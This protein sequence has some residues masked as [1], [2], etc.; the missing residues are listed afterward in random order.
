MSDYDKEYY[1]VRKRPSDRTLPFLVPDKN[2][3][4]K[5]FGFEPQPPGSPPLVFYNGW[6]DEYRQRR[7][8]TS[9]PDILF[10]GS[11]L[12]V[13][14]PIRNRLLALNVPN[15]DMQSAVYIDDRDQ[16]H[17]D[18]WYLTFLARFECWDREK[19]DYEQEIEPI[20]LGGFELYQ[21]YEYSLDEKLLDNTPLNQ[22]L[23]FQM[24]GTILA[25]V[26]CHESVRHLFD[27]GGKSG[28]E[29]TL[30]TDY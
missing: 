30:V 9:C 1:F 13:R 16:W 22:R 15:L 12:V 11:D 28:A 18:F 27:G 20:R 3:E 4:D 8:V 2:T 24:G 21:V 19:S 26:V 6:K 29:L 10:C 17:E 7:I 25:D 14:T 5:N 23:L